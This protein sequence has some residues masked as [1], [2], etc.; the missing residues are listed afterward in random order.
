M[1]LHQPRSGGFLGE[2]GK[3]RPSP[4]P[5]QQ[6]LFGETRPSVP[7]W[8]DLDRPILQ[9][10]IYDQNSFAL[11]AAGRTLFFDASVGDSL[12]N[13]FERF[14]KLTGRHYAPIKHHGDSD[15]VFVVQGAAV[16]TAMTVADHL[17]AGPKIHAGVLD[18]TTLRPFPGEQIAQAL[19]GCS[20]VVVLERHQVPLGTEPPLL[21]EIRS[22]LEKAGD[23]EKTGVKS[24]LSHAPPTCHSVIY[25]LGGLPLR[26]A[27]LAAIPDRL[28]KKVSAQFFL[29]LDFDSRVDRYPKRRVLLDRLERAYPNIARHGLRDNAGPLKNH[30]DRHHQHCGSA[31]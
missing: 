29:G 16:E 6:I 22:A 10:A 26:A 30:S 20:D 24:M 18:I 8:H 31:V 4:T 25:G 19:K 1:S 27:D 28:E 13:S 5:A 7:R 21:R 9:G 15:L 23:T 2:S 3:N 11:G 14:A 12:A 17:R